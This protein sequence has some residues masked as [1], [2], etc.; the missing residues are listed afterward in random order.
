MASIALSLAPRLA[1]NVSPATA[2]ELALLPIARGPRGEG[3]SLTRADLTLQTLIARAR[4]TMGANPFAGKPVLSAGNTPTLTPWHDP[5]PVEGQPAYVEAYTR[6]Y[7]ATDS[8][9]KPWNVLGGEPVVDGFGVRV[10][11]AHRNVSARA[12][13]VGWFEFVL[14]DDSAKLVLEAGFDY[15]VMVLEDG[16][17]KYAPQANV[18]RQDGVGQQVFML[19]FPA[20][21]SRVRRHVVIETQSDG[22]HLTGRFGGVWVKTGAQAMRPAKPDLRA[23]WM[24]DSLGMGGGFAGSACTVVTA[25]HLGIS[26][27]WL[28]AVDSTGASQ[29]HNG[30]FKWGERRVD[31]QAPDPD[32]LFFGLS[33][34]DYGQVTDNASRLLVLGT[35][36]A[37]IQAA[38]AALAH[39]VVLVVGLLW[40]AEEFAADPGIPAFNTTVRQAVR[41]LNDK[42]VLFLEPNRGAELPITGKTGASAGNVMDYNPDHYTAEGDLWVGI[43]NAHTALEA[44]TDAFHGKAPADPVPIAGGTVIE[45]EPDPAVITPASASISGVVGQAVDLLLGTISNGVP[46]GVTGQA[47]GGTAFQVVGQQLLLT[48][49]YAQAA[50][51]LY[52]A[53]VSTSEGP[54]TFGLTAAVG[55]SVPEQPGVEVLADLRFEAANGSTA[56]LNDAANA[57]PFHITGVAEIRAASAKDGIGGF[58]I[59]AAPGQEGGALSDDVVTF[60]GPFRME[61]DFRDGEWHYGTIFAIGAWDSPSFLC[62]EHSVGKIDMYRESAAQDQGKLVEAPLTFSGYSHLAMSRDEQNMVRAEVEGEVVLG[63]VLLEGPISGRI[64]LGQAADGGFPALGAEFDNFKV[65]AGSAS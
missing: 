58:K 22:T 36:M 29:S 33:W 37:E 56:L 14:D 40:S 42:L 1:V 48:G 55:A 8:L 53:T 45:P 13:R 17:L 35:I 60:D 27:L 50:S 5:L 59:L 15:R 46:S 7:S 61:V 11:A 63:P 3:G 34:V 21:G 52:T 30:S 20:S 28:S 6:R 2:V 32:V 64:A 26:D 44:L 62:L 19:Q 18:T 54:V 43:N 24:V 49:T 38:R 65:T 12:G 41:A 4:Y 39:A 10:M 51:A 9:A 47:P 57:I 16:H 23:V 25:R 31:W